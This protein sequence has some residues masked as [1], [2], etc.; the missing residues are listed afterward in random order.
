MSHLADLERVNSHDTALRSLTALK[1]ESLAGG[2][3]TCENG[4]Y[5][6]LIRLRGG[7]VEERNRVLTHHGG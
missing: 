1:Q 3:I 7:R 5:G 6:Q 4:T 2:W